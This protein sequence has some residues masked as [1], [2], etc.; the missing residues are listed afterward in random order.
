M[1]ANTSLSLT[2]L[3]FDTLKANFKGFLTSQSQ[4]KDFNFEG[5]NMNVLLDVMTYNT[6][7]N[8]FYLNMVSSEMFL[9]SA[10]KYDSVV[11]HAKEL[12]YLPKSAK[13]S[14][15]TVTFTADTLGITPPFSI[16]KGVTFS[17]TNS[18]GVFTFTTNQ[19]HN[20]Q[21]ANSTYQI[22]G[23]DLYDGVYTNDIFIMDYSIESQKF[24]LTNQNID[25]D[26]LTVTI[27]ESGVDTIFS[28]VNTLFGLTELSNVY[29]LQGAQDGLYE[30]VFGDGLFGRQPNNLAV[31]NINY[32]V[33]SGPAADGISQFLCTMDLGAINGGAAGIS[34]PVATSI[35]AGG[36]DPES[37]E[38]IRFSA[39][40]YYATQQRAI[41]QDDFTSLVLDNYG[42]LIDACSV[43]GGETLEPKQYGRVVVSLKPTG[44]TIAP[45]YLKNE[46]SS[47]LKAY[48][49]LPTRIIIA[50]PEYFYL[51]INTTVQYD[52]TSTTKLVAELQSLIVNSIDTWGQAN[53]GQFGTDFRYSKFVAAID[54]VDSSI[55]SNNTDVYMVKRLSPLLGYATGFSIS[56][57]NIAN[58]EGESPG[59]VKNKPLSD[60][61]ILTST[62]F[63]YVDADG[64]SYDNCYFRDD[65][66]GGI[67][68][69]TLINGQFTIVNSNIGQVNY[70]TGRVDIQKFITTSYD[71]YISINYKPLN[72]DVIIAQNSIA[73][74]DINSYDVNV[75]VIETIK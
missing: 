50:D 48:T 20:Y 1:A 40:R 21:S 22:D 16:P 5:S 57:N 12:N 28:R 6:Y 33:C 62:K 43:Y 52:K 56:F 63:T 2:S 54:S 73:L 17:G 44:G 49:S 18:N 42:G 15:A 14:L 31:I 60:E 41:A 36:A 51:G 7:L 8:A 23:L 25:V 71:Q 29:F 4:F 11:S 10:Q 59:Y 58:I 24:L 38:S 13:S 39:P 66:I 37:I 68:I 27:T 19:L 64:N 26:S 32:R 55:T 34:T 35:S 46:I 65:N 53:L 74:I 67:L 3:D 61:P 47:Y 72:K 69:Y 30:I 70:T 9:D 75:N 45:D